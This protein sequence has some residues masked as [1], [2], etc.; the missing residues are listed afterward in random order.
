MASFGAY[1]RLYPT[2]R[3]QSQARLA[4]A[5]A[6]SKASPTAMAIHTMRL[7]LPPFQGRS[8]VQEPRQ[9]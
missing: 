1:P 6:G 3:D 2:G 7:M 8:T 9:A 4:E 5:T